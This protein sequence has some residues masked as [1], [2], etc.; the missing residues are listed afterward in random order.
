MTRRWVGRAVGRWQYRVDY[1]AA[2]G[3]ETAQFFDSRLVAFFFVWCLRA[4]GVRC[5]LRVERWT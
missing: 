4:S 2:D 1:V 3:L 5:S